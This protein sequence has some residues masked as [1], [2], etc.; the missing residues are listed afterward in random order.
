MQP[1]NAATRV[2]P[3]RP[4]RK[5]RSDPTRALS[6]REPPAHRSNFDFL[7][8]R[9]RKS[10][11]T[12]T[13]ARFSVRPD[14]RPT[15]VGPTYLPFKFHLATTTRSKVGVYADRREIFG[16][17]R[18][19]PDWCRA[20]LPTLQISSRYDYAFESRCLRRPS[21]DFRSDPTCAVMVSGQGTYPSN[22]IFLRRRVRKSVFTPTV[23]RFSVRP[24][25]HRTGVGPIY[26]HSKFRVDTTTRCKVG[27]PYR[28]MFI[29]FLGL[30]NYYRRFVSSYIEASAH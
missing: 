28:R 3:S 30:S 16:P 25:V 15:G 13:V 5:F 2:R 4:C 17:T 27:S 21:R 1:R 26:L 8:R 6:V 9:V 23:A 7:R 12:P 11:F 20:Y 22:F 10:V 29:T 24:D 14:V 18:R 19:A